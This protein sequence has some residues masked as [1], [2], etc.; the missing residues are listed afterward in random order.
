MAV[1]FKEGGMKTFL[2]APAQFICKNNLSLGK[3]DRV[4]NKQHQEF[5]HSLPV[6]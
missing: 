1:H 2:A 6:T 5:S 3:Q 4:K